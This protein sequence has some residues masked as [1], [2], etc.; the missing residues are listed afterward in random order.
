MK[1]YTF[2]KKNA[3]EIAKKQ[4]MS[5]FFIVILSVFFGLLMANYQTNGLVFSN[6][7]TL[8]GTLIIIIISLF[9]GLKRRLK[10]QIQCLIYEK[11]ILDV[12]SIKKI[13]KSSNPVKINYLDIVR[14]E[15][16]NNEIII[17]GENQ[18]IKVPIQISNYN[19]FKKTLIE[20]LERKVN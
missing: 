17:I 20:K 14:Y 16:K 19:D 11:I 2:T 4:I 8:I 7:L 9:F 10:T 5:L 6:P 1:E 18:K 3:E 13:S 12:D 15:Q